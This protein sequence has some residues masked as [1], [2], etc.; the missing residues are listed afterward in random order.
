[1]RWPLLVA[2]FAALING[3]SLRST[4]SDPVAL[5]LPLLGGY[6]LLTAFAIFQIRKQGRL[7]ECF[8]L[9]G[10]DLS[11]GIMLGL[12]LLAMAWLIKTRLVPSGSDREGWLFQIFLLTGPIVSSTAKT[13]AL[14]LLA[15]M[16]EVIWRGFVAHD[17]TQALGARRALPLAAV[18]YAV[19]VLPTAWTLAD[20]SA[21]LNPLIVLA[22]L[23]CGICWTFL[24]LRSKRLFAVWI[25][26][27][28]FSYFAAA[29]L[30]GKL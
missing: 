19:A 2:A 6:S 16:E 27:A 9:K 22:A 20:A 4:A 1:M 10:G 17:L 8:T 24:A 15:A 18:L 30:V 23:G 21:G 5:W 28:V 7:S 25:S 29:H 3:I 12:G 11:I 26:H 13:L 14:V